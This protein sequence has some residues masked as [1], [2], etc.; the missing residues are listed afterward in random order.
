MKRPA[1]TVMLLLAGMCSLASD[2]WAQTP[3]AICALDSL[4]LMSPASIGVEYVSTGRR[5]VIVSWPEVE[6]MVSTC[7]A[8]ADTGGIAVPITL[9]GIYADNVDRELNMLCLF[10]G[11][12]GTSG[13][14]NVII[15]W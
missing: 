5:G 13:V 9:D 15:D 14:S 2:C 1:V 7:I 3:S 12:V 8:V 6:D 11:E 10:G 4:R